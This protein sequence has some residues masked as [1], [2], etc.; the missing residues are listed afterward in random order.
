VF[1][2][3]SHCSGLFAFHCEE[4]KEPLLDRSVNLFRSLFTPRL[5]T[6]PVVV[7]YAIREI[8]TKGNDP[9]WWRGRF[10]DRV[11]RP[12]FERAHHSDDPTIP[13]ADWDSLLLLDA[14]RYDLFAETARGLPGELS[15]RTAHDSATPRYLA[16]NFAGGQFH[17]IVYVTANPYVNTRLP[18]GTFHHVVPVWKS[19]WDDDLQVVPPEAMLEATLEAYAEFE[20]KRLLVHFT[21]PHAPFIGDVQLGERDVSPIRE[22][23]LGREADSA[24]PTPFEMLARGDVSRE[25][26]WRAYRANLECVLP[27]VQTLLAELEGK[28]VITADHGNALGE[29]AKPFPLRVY[30]HP[31]G[32]R[33]PPLT[34]VPW[35]V[36]V[37]G[38]RR[39]VQAEP[40]VSTETNELPDVE[41]RLEML[42]YKN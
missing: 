41:E 40:P 9:E 18:D 1:T 37:S 25:E 24:N 22:R 29:W 19:G 17:D 38:E 2:P 14:C 11:A 21:Q 31:P 4:I 30:G 35:H 15:R 34:E 33:I 36:H 26:V 12:Y 5:D 39:D 28:T 42:G 8:A 20:D 3:R 27:A 23:A 16:E 13:E 10:L 32:I 7:R 6:V